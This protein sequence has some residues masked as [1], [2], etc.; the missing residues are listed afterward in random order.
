MCTSLVSSTLRR[1]PLLMD[2]SPD[3]LPVSLDRHGI[4]DIALK[5]W[6]FGLNASIVDVTPEPL[7]IDAMAAE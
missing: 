6:V 1:P 7:R 3:L 5:D 2:V 4:T